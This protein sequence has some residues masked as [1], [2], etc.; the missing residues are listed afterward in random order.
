MDSVSNLLK[1]PI[2]QMTGEEFLSLSGAGAST[3]VGTTMSVTLATG[4]AEL[5]TKLSCS[6][7]TIYMLRRHN[8]LDDAVVSN[9]GRRIIF[10]V[11]KA[12]RLADQY[13]REHRAE[14]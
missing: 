2:W 4:V 9:I 5:A 14:K 3:S 11:E 7:S 1:K 10:D 6:A 13:Q 12:R 8:V